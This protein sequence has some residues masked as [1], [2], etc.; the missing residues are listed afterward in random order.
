[1]RVLFIIPKDPPPRLEGGFSDEF[2]GFV[3]ACL[4]VRA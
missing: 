4:Q 3:A 2:K 1:M